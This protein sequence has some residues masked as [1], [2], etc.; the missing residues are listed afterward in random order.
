VHI[1]TVKHRDASDLTVDLMSH[2][3]SNQ[4]ANEREKHEISTGKIQT[5]CLL[6]QAYESQIYAMM[7]GVRTIGQ[8]SLRFPE[9]MDQSN[10][11]FTANSQ[12]NRPSLS[13]IGRGVVK[14]IRGSQVEARNEM[15]DIAEDYCLAL[16]DQGIFPVCHCG[17]G[18]VKVIEGE[19]R[20]GGC[21]AG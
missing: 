12:L 6:R 7:T 19:E 1:S 8:R 10:G 15:Y 3:Q 11:R 5:L 16:D 20:E 2:I 13:N 21:E 4:D 9:I 18:R 14:E 17:N